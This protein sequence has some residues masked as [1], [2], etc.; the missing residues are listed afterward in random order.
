[1]EQY[2]RV[3]SRI[4]CP[5]KESVKNGQVRTEFISQ[6]GHSYP[7]SPGLGAKLPS[8]I[9]KKKRNLRLKAGNKHDIT[10]GISLMEDEIRSGIV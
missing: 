4:G 1:M 3:L 5:T 8:G 9:G 10:D 2:Y 7:R 6:L